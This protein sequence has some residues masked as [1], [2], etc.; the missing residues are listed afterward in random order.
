MRILLLSRYGPRGPSSRLR[1]YQFLPALAEAGMSVAVAPLLPDSYLEALYAGRQRPL[2]SI[3]GAYVS[4][5]RQMASARSF[6]LLWI[7]K[8]LLPWIPYGAER[9]ILESAPPYIVDFDDAWFHH[10]DRNRWPLVRRLLGSK[11]DRVMQHAALVTV[12]NGYLAKRAESAGARSIATLP[13]VVDLTRYPAAPHQAGGLPAVG[14]IGSPITDHYLGLVEEPLRR[15][16]M[17]N[18]AR[19]CLV[20]AT[21]AALSGL[22]ADR[23]EWREDTETSRIAAFD[24]GIMPLADTPW[25]RGKCGYKLI[26]YMACGKPV[27]ASPVG[28]NRDIVEH[29]VNGFL[30]ETPE[31]WTS[32]LRRL[33]NDPD[34][35][36]RLGVAGRAKVEQHYSLAGTAPRLAELLRAAPHN[37]KNLRRA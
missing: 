14:W 6:D 29:G 24:I 34:L 9:W 23:H 4:R 3:V 33:A 12:G 2:R 27:V 13:T 7:E 32:A 36:R 17:G 15:M 18:E 31:E 35:R 37:A 19:L 16:V 30:A 25:E 26:Q 28:V 8:E 22:P 21:P 10:Y 20:G 1:H 11:L 5:I